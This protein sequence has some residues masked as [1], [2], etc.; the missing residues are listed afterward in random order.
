MTISPH[1]FETDPKRPTWIHVC[2]EEHCRW[3]VATVTPFPVTHKCPWLGGPTRYGWSIVLTLIEEMWHRLDS[4]MDEIQLT[5][6]PERAPVRGDNP[7]EDLEKYIGECEFLANL[8]GKARGAAEMIAMF[9]KPYFKDANEVA[10]EARRRAE[11]RAR[12]D[13]EYETLGLGHLQLAPPPGDMDKYKREPKKATPKLPVSE[14]D[15]ERIR[16]AYGSFP[17]DILCKTFHVTPAQLKTIA[18]SV[19]AGAQA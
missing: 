8:K 2:E 5:P 14:E 1:P 18:E 12:K 10:R 15:A 11:A 19:P 6:V 4:I 13:T 7:G 3:R 17:E 9:S 16:R